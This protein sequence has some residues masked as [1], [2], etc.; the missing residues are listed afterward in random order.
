MQT[1]AYAVDGPKEK[2]HRWNITRRN[3]KDHDVKVEIMYTGVCHSD[4]HQARNE[5]NISKY[6]MVPGHEIL[7][8]IVEIGSKVSKFKEGEWRELVAL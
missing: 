1:V 5:W 4:I 2:F 6:P 8:K 3:L 7:G